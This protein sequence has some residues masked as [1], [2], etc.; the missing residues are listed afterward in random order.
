MEMGTTV[1]GVLLLLMT[2]QVTEVTKKSKEK[3]GYTHTVRIHLSGDVAE[4]TQPVVNA[5]MGLTIMRFNK[6]PVI[7]LAGPAVF[8]QPGDISIFLKILVRQ[9]PTHM[10]I[11]EGDIGYRGSVEWEIQRRDAA[12]RSQI[13]WRIGQKDFQ[14]STRTA[15]SRLAHIL[16]SDADGIMKLI[17]LEDQAWLDR[18]RT[19]DGKT[20]MDL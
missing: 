18:L 4:E 15:L 16:R 10:M 2:T 8:L 1:A 6:N 20:Y 19:H 7:S 3:K 13:L 14:F 12:N 11:P 5:A 17:E 9:D